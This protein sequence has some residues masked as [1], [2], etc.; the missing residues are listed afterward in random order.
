[1]D[2]QQLL[3]YAIVAGAAAYMV[4]RQF[5]RAGGCGGCNS[6]ETDKTPSS[7]AKPPLVQLELGPPPA[8]E[9]ATDR[10]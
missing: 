10:T 3:V 7:A 2:W 1:M 6:C 5:R 9:D 4:R 8:R